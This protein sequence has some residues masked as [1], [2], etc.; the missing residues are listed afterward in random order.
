MDWADT[1]EQAT[2]RTEVRKFINASL[3]QYYKKQAEEGGVLGGEG[4]WQT[5]RFLGTPEAKAAARDWGR[6]A[7]RARLGRPALAEGVRRRRHSTAW[8]SSSSTRSWPST[9][10]PDSAA[11]AS[12][13]LGPTLIVHG[14]EEQKQKYLPP[15]LTGEMRLGAGLLRAGRRLRPRLAADARRPRRR[16]VRD[17]RPEDLD[18][19]AHTRRLDL[20]P[21]RAPTRTRRST[22]ASRSCMMDMKTPGIT[23]PPADQHGLAARLQRDVLRGRARPGRPASSAR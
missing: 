22:A 9:G 3:P 11:R 14:T 8:S 6:G 18:L 17:Q 15:T 20:R 16:R 23:R 2:F 21:R 12:A 7:R 1:P 4:G 5:D 13:M 19:R 10:A